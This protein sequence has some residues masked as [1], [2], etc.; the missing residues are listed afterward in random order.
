M[1]RPHMWFNLA[2]AGG[3]HDAYAASD[4][5]A[6]LLA[7]AEVSEVQRRARVCLASNY[8]DCD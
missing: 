3:Q 4:R 5:V 2:G 6:A 8:R 1:S 7:P